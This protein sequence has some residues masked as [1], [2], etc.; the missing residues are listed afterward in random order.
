MIHIHDQLEGKHIDNR[1]QSGQ[2]REY[3]YIY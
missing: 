2:E 1:K 3:T